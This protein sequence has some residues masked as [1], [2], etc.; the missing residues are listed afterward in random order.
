[1]GR[2]RSQDT[3]PEIALRRALHRLGLRFRLGGAGLPGRP[4]IVLP[5]HRAAV[6]V[7]GCFW[8][9]HPGCKVASTPKSNTDFWVARF[10]RNVARDGKVMRELQEL[11][12]NVFVIWE[13]ELSAKSRLS[14]TATQLA[15]QIRE[16]TITSIA[17]VL[18]QTG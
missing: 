18:P 10:D 5:R 1:M 14:P 16:R 7:H 11:G 13:C 15:A 8:H 2:I 9:R 4:D 3:K 12:W 6:F 17:G